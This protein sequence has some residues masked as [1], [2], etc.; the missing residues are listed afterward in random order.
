MICYFYVY[1]QKFWQE[2]T[3]CYMQHHFPITNCIKLYPFQFFDKMYLFD[4]KCILIW[5]E[6]SLQ[7]S[8]FHQTH[9]YV[10]NQR[11]HFFFKC[12]LIFGY[13]QQLSIFNFFFII[14]KLILIILIVIHILYTLKLR[15]KLFYQNRLFI[16]NFIFNISNTSVLPN[17]QST[18]TSY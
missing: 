15:T 3:D 4:V 16:I 2:C 8:K 13:F 17:K 12:F 18:S 11:E 6:I 5:E 10:Q 7:N 9:I 1:T 14:K